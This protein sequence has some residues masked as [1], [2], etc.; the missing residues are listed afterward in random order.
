MKRGVYAGSFDPVTNG[1]LWM[2]EQGYQLFDEMI[3][4]I[5]INPDKRCTFS[6]E[7]REAM[8]RETTSHLP[9][10]KVAS[11][12]NQFLVNYARSVGANYILRGIRTASDYE[13]ERTM[14]YVNSDLVSGIVTVFLMPPREIAEVSS[15][16]VKGLVGPEGW[17]D[18]LRNYVPAPVYQ[19]FINRPA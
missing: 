14:R 8:L 1:H 18:V 13:F 11:F 2:I 7:E 19:R 3:V 10:L 4:A 15:T 16:M 12:E 17:Q 9:N 6:V 5:G